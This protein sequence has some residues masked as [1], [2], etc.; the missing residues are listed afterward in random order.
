MKTLMMEDELY[1]ALEGEAHKVGYTV[2]ELVAEAVSFWLADAELDE[3]ERAEIEAAR[4]EAAR[5][6]GVEAD[7]FFNQLLKEPN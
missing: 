5:M 7:E 3:R 1:E 4:V 6:G 2:G